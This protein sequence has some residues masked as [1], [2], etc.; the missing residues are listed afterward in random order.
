V[1]TTM[2]SLLA[3]RGE[4]AFSRWASKIVTSAIRL[5]TTGPALKASGRE[6]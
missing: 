1:G 2:L 6:A 5:S 3:T 4:A